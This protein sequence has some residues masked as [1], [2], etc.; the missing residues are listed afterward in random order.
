MPKSE[1]LDFSLVKSYYHIS[2]EGADAPF[3]E[4]PAAQLLERNYALEALAK[5][6]ASWK[7]IGMELPVSF[8]GIP[9]F[10]LGLMNLLFSAQYNQFIK[11]PLSALTLQ[12]ENHNDHV[13]IG[14]KI[15]E[16]QTVDI[17][18]DPVERAS[19]IANEWS[20]FIG[21]TVI[22]AFDA[23]AE[24]A[25]LKPDIIWNQFGAAT[26]SVLAYVRDELQVPGLIDLIEA[27][28]K[29]IEALPA[30]VFKRRR[31]PY[32]HKPRY[33]DNPWSPPDG[34]LIIRSSCCMYD[35]REEGTKCYNCPQMLPA[36]R[37]ERRQKILVEQH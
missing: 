36:E 17:P 16:L 18:T 33:I 1:M 21:E 34:Q 20:E 14:F 32:V 31:N 8:T 4:L 26:H 29:I 22:P 30:E 3:Y 13:H 19:V 35:R 10:Y 23:L 12:L 11:L 27:D 5:K 24:A 37:E 7:A 25:E 9:F 6:G 2:P 15:N 28:F